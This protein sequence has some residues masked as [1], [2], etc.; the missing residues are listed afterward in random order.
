MFELEKGGVRCLENNFCIMTFLFFL[1]K[2]PSLAYR[3][4]CSH[5]CGSYLW[6]HEQDMIAENRSNRRR[7]GGKY[8]YQVD[9]YF[10]H[11]QEKDVIL[12]KKGY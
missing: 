11:F 3:R 1:Q 5:L 4:S 10:F 8:L 6:F 2:P 12:S 9:A 7:N